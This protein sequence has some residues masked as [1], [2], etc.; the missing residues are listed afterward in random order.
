MKK[1]FGLGIFILSFCLFMG[2]CAD[3]KETEAQYTQDTVIENTESQEDE[4]L[5]RLVFHTKVVDYSDVPFEVIQTELPDNE[6][7]VNQDFGKEKKGTGKEPIVRPREEEVLPEDT[8]PKE[9]TPTEEAVSEPEP[10]PKVS[11]PNSFGSYPKIT[12]DGNSSS[13]FV[14]TNYCYLESEKYFIMFDKDLSIPGDF[15]VIIDAIVDRLEAAMG[16]SITPSGYRMG[17]GDWMTAYLGFNPWKGFDN[18]NKPVIYIMVD[19]ESEGWISCASEDAAVIVLYELYTD[20][21]WNSIPEYRDNPWRRNDY[22]DY[23]DIAHELTHLITDRNHVM[24]KIMTEGTGEYFQSWCMGNL[25]A[26]FPVIKN[27]NERRYSY[28]NPLPEEITRDNAERIF[29]EDYNYIDHANRGAEYTLG[30]YLC[31]Y[32]HQQ[33]GNGFVAMYINELKKEGIS[34][35][36]GNYNVD[37]ITKMANAMKV[38]FG[39]DVFVKFGTWWEEGRP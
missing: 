5:D 1:R 13:L 36:Y 20:E 12:L 31:K 9:D 15:A 11:S 33:F 30:K 35:Y 32:L 14:T 8:T 6:A 22:I 16:L 24:S 18:K 38:T 7:P 34:Y 19:R 3:F 37:T 28:D 25:S 23:I 29:I 27:A 21:L 10:A 4:S 17:M 26:D 2:G 39:D